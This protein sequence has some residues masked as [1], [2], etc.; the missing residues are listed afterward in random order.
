MAADHEDGQSVA[1]WTTVGLLLV[2][3][4]LIS[5]G[6]GFGM[7]WLDIAGIVLAGIAL[8]VGKVLSMAG[9]GVDKPAHSSHTHRAGGAAAEGQQPSQG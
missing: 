7:L 8:V 4:A 9:F 5:L 3:A 1:S 6:I 2:A